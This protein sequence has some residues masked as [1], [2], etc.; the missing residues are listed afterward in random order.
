[1]HNPDDDRAT[2]ILE[3]MGLMDRYQMIDDLKNNK[4]I[5]APIDFNPVNKRIEDMRAYAMG[6]LVDSLK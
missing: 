3:Q 2:A 4:N 1:M 5:M 6:Y